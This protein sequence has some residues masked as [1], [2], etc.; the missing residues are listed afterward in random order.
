MFCTGRSECQKTEVSWWHDCKF[1]DMVAAG[2]RNDAVRFLPVFAHHTSEV[3]Y[4][5]YPSYGFLKILFTIRKTT[6]Q[7]REKV[8]AERRNEISCI[9]RF[10]G[11]GVQ[12]YGVF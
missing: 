6:H 7:V 12:N 4:A 3:E 11:I 2:C 9:C 10:L 5:R 1:Y 8:A